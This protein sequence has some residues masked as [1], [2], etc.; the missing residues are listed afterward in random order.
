MIHAH[1]YIRR[2]KRT[3]KAGRTAKNEIAK[4]VAFC[5]FQRRFQFLLTHRQSGSE[6]GETSGQ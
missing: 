6:D 5:L 3:A 2:V 4:S 1:P